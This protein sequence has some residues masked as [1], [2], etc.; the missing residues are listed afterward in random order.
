M[1][2]SWQTPEQKTFIE[3]HVPSYA[4]HSEVGTLKSDF[5]PDFLAKWFEKWPLPGPT[6][7]RIEKEGSVG[8][9]TQV[10]RTK[11]ATVSTFT[12]LTE[13]DVEL[14][15]PYSKSSVSSKQQ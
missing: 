11:K 13:R 10:D 3:E 15:C 12:L 7:D 8:K 1:G 5:W 14:T 4:R 2:G 9:A 6:A